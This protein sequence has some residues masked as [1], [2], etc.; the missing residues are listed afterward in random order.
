MKFMVVGGGATGVEMAG[1]IAATLVVCA[2]GVSATLTAPAV[3]A[4]GVIS[5]PKIGPVFAPLI[6]IGTPSLAAISLIRPRLGPDR[7]SIAT[8]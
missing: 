3:V 1:A 2:P 6:V 4:S 5:W 7:F 8:W